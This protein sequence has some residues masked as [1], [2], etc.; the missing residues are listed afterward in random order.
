MWNTITNDDCLYLWK[1]LRNNIQIL[2]LNDKLAAVA[3]FTSTMPF[4][5]RTIDYYSPWDWPTPWEI[6]FHGMFC[7]SSISLLI[8]YTLSLLNESDIE[9][10]LVEDDDVYLLPVVN[11]TYVLNYELG[12]VITLEEISKDI[13]VLKIYTSEDINEVI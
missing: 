7:V 12:K 1:E 10:Y 4:G 3:K 5:H 8:Y 13:K 11:S 6:L 2:P 9:L